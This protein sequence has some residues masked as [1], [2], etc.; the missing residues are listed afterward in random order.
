RLDLPETV[1]EPVTAFK[2][3]VRFPDDA[4]LTKVIVNGRTLRPE[5]VVK[6][7]KTTDGT[8]K[9]EIEVKEVALPNKGVKNRVVLEVHNEDGA[10]KEERAV[11]FKAVPPPKPTVSVRKQGAEGDQSL[12]F[13]QRPVRFHLEVRSEK[14]RLRRVEVKRDGR[15]MKSLDV[16][17]QK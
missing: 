17:G 15:T 10:G 7:P 11:E 14:V 13:T 6:N 1:T 16:A 3:V 9:A 12:I 2:A 8:T 4:P 5:D